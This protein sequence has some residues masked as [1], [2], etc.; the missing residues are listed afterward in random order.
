MIWRLWRGVARADQAAN[1]EQHL[2]R[3]TFPALRT[4]EGF[5]DASILTRSLATG[6]EF[7]VVSRWV[8]ME[9]IATFAGKDVE[10]AVVPRNVEQMMVEF[11]RTVTHYTLVV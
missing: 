1:Y 6:V 3:E 4:I 9:N 7:L 8:S 11:D 5:V 2:R 10:A